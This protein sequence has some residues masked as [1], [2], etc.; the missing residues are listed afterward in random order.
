[1]SLQYWTRHDEAFFERYGTVVAE[2]PAASDEVLDWRRYT[3]VFDFD[4]GAPQ[5]R[6]IWRWGWT[7]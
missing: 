3:F 5:I 6:G 1:V 2:T 4:D 7:P